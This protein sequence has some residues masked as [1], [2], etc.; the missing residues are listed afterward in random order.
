MVRHCGWPL[1]F[2][3]EE[4]V[5]A[6]RELLM[7]PDEEGGSIVKSGFMVIDLSLIALLFSLFLLIAALLKYA[8]KE[9]VGKSRRERAFC[10]C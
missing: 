7:F 5:P 4:G 6:P 3:D 2:E 10:F 1:S 8:L 9:R